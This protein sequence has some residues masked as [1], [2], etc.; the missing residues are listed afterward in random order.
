M[1]LLR[2]GR[3]P[4]DGKA[5][6]LL[7]SLA[8][9]IETAELILRLSI[10]EIARGVAVDIGGIGRIGWKRNGRNA[11]HVILAERNEGLAHVLRDRARRADVGILVC[12]LLEVGE[13]FGVVL[14]H[15][16]SGG[17]GGRGV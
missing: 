7:H 15:V 2:G 9:Q 1:L 3:E 4:V 8:A 10:T 6:I 16:T 12:D 5:W 13:G 14:G 11:S 17:G